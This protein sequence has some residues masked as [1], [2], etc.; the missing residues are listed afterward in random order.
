MVCVMTCS[1]GPD[2]NF[3]PAPAGPTVGSM[4]WH[5]SA[6]PPAVQ[7]ENGTLAKSHLCS[8]RGATAKGNLGDANLR[9]EFVQGDARLAQPTPEKAQVGVKTADYMSADQAPNSWRVTV[10]KMKRFVEFVIVIARL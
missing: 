6:S 1:S 5:D 7:L 9:M 2:L 4:Q 10:Y 3:G 8:E